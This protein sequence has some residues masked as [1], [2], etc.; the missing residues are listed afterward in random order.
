MCRRQRVGGIVPV[1]VHLLSTN[2]TIWE[3]ECPCV[4]EQRPPAQPLRRK[5]L[6][7]PAPYT[8]YSGWGMSPW[9]RDGIAFTVSLCLRPGAPPPFPRE[10]GGFY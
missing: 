8:R 7:R 3:R 9:V 10:K 5:S 1:P 2:K 6:L 4:S